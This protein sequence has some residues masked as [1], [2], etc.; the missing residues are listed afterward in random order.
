MKFS[1]NSL[2]FLILIVFLVKQLECICYKKSYGRGV[3][4]PLSRCESGYERNG[5]LCYPNCKDG[6]TGAGPVCWK[7]CD[8]GYDNHGATCCNYFLN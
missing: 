1:F 7:D 5:A 2:I 4:E 8:D 3:G 6:Y